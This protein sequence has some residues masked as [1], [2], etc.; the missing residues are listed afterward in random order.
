MMCRMLRNLAQLLSLIVGVIGMSAALIGC[1]P[2]DAQPTTA[3]TASQASEH[4][5]QNSNQRLNQR[6]LT[7]N[8]ALRGAQIEAWWGLRAQEDGKLWRLEASTPA[9]QAQ[10][11]QWHHQTVRVQGTQPSG[12]PAALGDF[13]VLLV[14]QVSLAN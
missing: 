14:T 5:S 11:K 10:F 4:I 2:L 8:I 13:P 12:E 7:G 6:V 1:A 9:I 3:A